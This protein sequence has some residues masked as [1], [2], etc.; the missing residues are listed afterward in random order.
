MKKYIKAEPYNFPFDQSM[1]ADNTALMIID[2]QHD[3][4]GKGG[5]IDQMGLDVTIT[6]PVI[7]PIKNLLAEVRKIPN[8]T[9]VY[10]RLGFKPDLSNIA[11]NRLWRSKQMEVGIGDQG[12]LGRNLIVG[13]PGL[14]ILPEIAPIEGEIIV[15][16]PGLGSFY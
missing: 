16:K 2:M 14:E 6:H 1:T 10:T 3:F 12:P 5:Y 4:L 8:F 13:E 9:V 11:P 15:D 7:E